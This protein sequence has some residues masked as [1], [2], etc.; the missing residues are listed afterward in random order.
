[1]RWSKIGSS[2]PRAATVFVVSDG[3]GRTCEHV[4]KAALVQYQ[5]H[6]V[7][8]ILKSNIRTA[9]QAAAVVQEAARRKAPIFYTLVAATPRKAMAEAAAKLSVPTVDVLQPVLAALGDLLQSIPQGKPGLYY[10]SQQEYFDRLE[11]VEYT[12]HDDG[13]RP[14]E[15][16]KADVVLVGLSRVSKSATCFVLAYNGIRAAN[17]PL[18]PGYFLP[19]ELLRLDPRRVIG[20]TMNADR[21]QRVREVRM[22]GMR[23]GT[24]E[25]YTDRRQILREIREANALMAQRGW[26]TID[27]S[28]RSIED[29]AQEVLRMVEGRTVGRSRR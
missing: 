15:L 14:Y 12:H 7:E 28:Y 3:S 2:R 9:R 16:R 11:A 23:M 20:L 22:H 5:D 27:V 17:V 8:L 1:M 6:D 4:V 18:V 13:Q 10:R 24:V 29:T 21:L 25:A 19:A 26:Q